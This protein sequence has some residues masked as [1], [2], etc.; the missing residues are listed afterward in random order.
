MSTAKLRT[1]FSDLV[2]LAGVGLAVYG[3]WRCYEPLAWIAGG[4]FL[5]LVA[6]ALLRR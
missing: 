2:F 4:V 3:L 5:A 6:V 1:V